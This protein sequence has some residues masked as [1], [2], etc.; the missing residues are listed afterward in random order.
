MSG[1]GGASGA[2]S[3]SIY[4]ENFHTELLDDNQTVGLNTSVVAVTNAMLAAANPFSGIDAYSPDTDV[5]NMSDRLDT[6][7]I[8]VDSISETVDWVAFEAQALAKVDDFLP[9]DANLNTRVEL[10][11]VNAEKTL[12][13]SYNRIS[14]SYFSVNGVIGTSLPSALAIIESEHIRGINS[15]RSDLEVGTK[16]QRAQLISNSINQMLSMYQLK[17]DVGL[18]LTGQ[19]QDIST[20]TILA[21]TDE[22]KSNTGLNIDEINWDMNIM[23]M[24]S[25]HLGAM[26]GGLA[27]TP[28]KEM[29]TA[30]SALGGAASGA[31]IGA[32]FGAQGAAIGA[33]V[34]GIAGAIVG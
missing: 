21:R 32:N 28:N 26:Q 14:A 12:A 13:R 11:E 33:I 17:Y 29:T 23:T 19:Q 30:Q 3:Y 27:S 18:R 4:M 20:K 31:A 8:L 34:G 5:Q 16:A 9:T 15:F 2:I 22:I 25:A 1:G 7:S 24:T 6:F 10:H